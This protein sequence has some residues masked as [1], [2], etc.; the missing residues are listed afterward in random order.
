MIANRLD[1]H[2]KSKK[3]DIQFLD[4]HKEIRRFRLVVKV[5]LPT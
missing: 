4:I 3:R 2:L 5:Q 1:R